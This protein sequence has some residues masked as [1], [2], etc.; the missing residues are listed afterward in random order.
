MPSP[1]GFVATLLRRMAG[2]AR[3]EVEI[4]PPEQRPAKPEW[5]LNMSVEERA[6]VFA[7]LFLNASPKDARVSRMDHFERRTP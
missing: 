2:G 3:A 5:D 1:V 6:D 7:S 4:L